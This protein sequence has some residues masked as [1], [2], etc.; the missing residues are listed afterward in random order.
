[1]D[2][3]MEHQ[4]HK[5]LGVVG[6]WW[7]RMMRNVSANNS[8][9]PNYFAATPEVLQ[10][11][12]HLGSFI[13]GNGEDIY[14]HICPS[15]ENAQDEVILVTCFWAR[16]SSLDMVSRS[17]RTLSDRVTKRRQAKV[18]VYIGFSS[19]SA[20]QKLFHTRSSRGKI[21]S[22]AQ[23]K[24]N[25]WLPDAAELPGLDLQ[26]KSL[27]VLPFSVMHPKFV[28][29][30]RQTVFLPSC[31]VSWE[32]WFEGCITL[33]GPIV[34]QFIIFWRAFWL[35]EATDPNVSQPSV[36]SDHNSAAINSVIDSS[37]RGAAHAITSLHHLP[38]VP[39]MF[40]PSPHHANPAFTF[41]WQKY[42]AAPT[43]PL[44]VFMLELIHS[45]SSSIYIQTPNVTAQPILGVIL[46]ALH[47][48]INVHILTSERLM[49]LEQLVTAGTTTARCV[50]KLV[51]LYKR[52]ASSARV[53]DEESRPVSVGSLRVEYYEPKAEDIRQWGE[54]VQSHFKLTIVDGEWTVLG[55]GNMD[56]ASWYT[57]Q[58][59]GVA[60]RSK[61]L[62]KLIETSVSDRM[63]G[64]TKLAFDS[65]AI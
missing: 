61:E 14:S 37:T 9:H 24:S 3:E 46:Q 44:N 45:A 63:V 29:I 38:S 35:Q 5:E 39:A 43:T 31:N 55:S 15:I 13:V 65:G 25:L 11:E 28:I 62:A 59:L 2:V 23:W 16:S 54:P 1:M 49:I 10:T 32:S 52:A 48:G 30:D 58:E 40:L 53:S 26:I 64:R 27:F 36:P 21:Y 6:N 7:Q 20:L 4:F 56:R 47:R 8:A 17:L 12:A 41:P 19:L 22:K 34:N 42:K 57:S 18:R 50:K 60:L 33:S 51:K